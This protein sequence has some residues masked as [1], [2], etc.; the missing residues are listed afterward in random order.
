MRKFFYIVVFLFIANM[1]VSAQS[2]NAAAE[3]KIEGF[4]AKVNVGHLVVN[5]KSNQSESSY[6]KVQ[7]SADGKSYTTIGFVL[8]QDPSKNDHEFSFKQP[9]AKIKP[10]LKYY[11]VLLMDGEDQAVASNSIKITK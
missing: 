1:S 6:W 4:T 7:G 8:G 3:V 9:V 2:A 10:G 5:W 11:R